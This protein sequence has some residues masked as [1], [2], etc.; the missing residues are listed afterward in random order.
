MVVSAK[1][2][3]NGRRERRR[4]RE[5]LEELGTLRDDQGG[6]GDQK[7]AQRA[8][9]SASPTGKILEFVAS[10]TT[11]PVPKCRLY[12]KNGLL[13]L[14]MARI[15][16]GVLLMDVATASKGAAA[17]AVEEQMK[18]SILP[19]LRSLRRRYIGSVDDALP[20][21]PPR[22]VYG[23][24]RRDWPQIASNSDEFVPCHN[25][26]GP[27]NIFVDPVTFKIVGIIDWEFAGFSPHPLNYRF[28]GNVI[29]YGLVSYMKDTLD[30]EGNAAC[31]ECAVN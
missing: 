25:D 30:R 10:R 22:R 8:R 29:V 23:R 12:T 27:Q 11:T 16:N 14:E 4:S 19:Q 26:L 6:E 17:Q 13:C 9:I 7:R 2:S 15:T 1:S 24:D 21:F 18:T 5:D 28:G 31:A 20:C 3:L